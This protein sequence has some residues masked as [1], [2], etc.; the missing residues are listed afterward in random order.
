MDPKR[1][2]SDKELKEI[3]ENLGNSDDEFDNSGDEFSD[4]VNF[5]ANNVDI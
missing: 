1:P 4:Y 3:L 2:L 5:E